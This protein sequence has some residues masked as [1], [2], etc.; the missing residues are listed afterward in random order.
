MK[1]ACINCQAAVR[2]ADGFD[3]ESAA[4]ECFAHMT[5]DWVLTSQTLNDSDRREILDR[6]SNS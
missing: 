6:R 4:D 3:G 5:L 2:N 1:Q